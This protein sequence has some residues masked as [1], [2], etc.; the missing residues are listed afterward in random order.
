MSAAAFN[1]YSVTAF[2]YGIWKIVV[3]A[4]DQASAIAKA[5]DIYQLDS[6]GGTYAFEPI[7]NDMAWDARL[8]VEEVQ[9]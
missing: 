7:L 5:K 4:G 9:R 2:D 3:E 1:R 6:L 8:L